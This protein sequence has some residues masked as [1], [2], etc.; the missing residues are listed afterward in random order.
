M[1]TKNNKQR[2]YARN[3]ALSRRGNEKIHESDGTYF[4]KLVLCIVL[5][6][7]WIKFQSPL[8]LGSFSVSGLPVGLLFGLLVVS[9]FEKFQYDRK[10][11]YAILVLVAIVSYFLPAGIV[12]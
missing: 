11:W 7:L 10:I 8:L 4:L 9:Q 5:G 2:T 1:A 3:R 12:V 6:T